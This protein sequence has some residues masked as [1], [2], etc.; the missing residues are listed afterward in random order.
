MILPSSSSTAANRQTSIDDD[1]VLGGRGVVRIA[2]VAALGGLLFGYDSAVINGA[3]SAVQSHFQADATSLGFAVAS[4]LLGAAA[5]ALLA[6]R[7]ADRLGRLAVMRIAAVLFL[8]SAIGTGFAPSLWVLILFRI[9]GGFGVG[10]AAVISPAYIAEIA[11]SRVRGRLGAL[12]QLAIVSGIFISLLIDFIIAEMAGGSGEPFWFG[13]EAWRWMFLAMAV[14]AI[15]YGALS[16]SIPESPRFLIATH[17]LSEAKAILTKLVGA[18]NIDAKV[19]RI[20]ETMEREKAPSWRDLKSP[21]GRIARVVWIGLGLAIFQQFIGINVI[22]YYSNVLWVAVGFDEGQAFV[23]TIISATINIVTT[24]IAIATIDRFGR[25]PLLIIGSIAM[26][27]TLTTMSIIFGTANV[28]NGSPV[29]EGAQGPIALIAANLFVV[30]FGM[31]WGPVV[32]VLLSEMFP[33]RMRAAGLSLATGGLWVSNW[34][35]TVTFPGLK[36]LSLAL[37][38]GF[39]ALCALLSLFFVLRFIEETKGKELEDVQG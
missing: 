38:Y 2:S 11:P 16:L 8:V 6:G 3:V 1:G 31:S 30:A 20:R 13:L 23:I 22:F 28:V 24:L 19:E 14:P 27:V 15:L 34:I 33:N 39:Y 36:D 17:R 10:M 25:K 26:T 5:G 18:A 21:N 7:L 35:I 37:A 12:Q 4:A 29:L 32:W 9:V